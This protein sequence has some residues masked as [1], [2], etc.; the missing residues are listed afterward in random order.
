MKFAFKPGPL[1]LAGGG[2]LSGFFGGLSGHQ[3]ALRS[4]F[5]SKLDLG[6]AAFIATG[7]G[8]ACMV[9]LS[10]LLLYA[11]NMDREFFRSHGMLLG[12][13]LAS[14][15][16]ASLLANAFL[17]KVDN[18]SLHIFVSVMLVVMGFLLMA[19]LL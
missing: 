2:L 6:P 11:G 17:K 12:V 5:L 18:L 10:R 4:A 9:D 1:Q 3:G 14:A 16:A 13:A 8:I 15:F 7:V 19:G